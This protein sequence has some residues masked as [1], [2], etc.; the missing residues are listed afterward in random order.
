M[1][2]TNLALVNLF[3]ADGN[4]RDALARLESATRDVRVQEKRVKALVEKQALGHKQLLDTQAQAKA[5]DLEVKSLDQHIEKLRNQQQVSRNNK[6]YQAFLVEINTAKLDKGKKEEEWLRLQES[7]E[8]KEKEQQDLASLIKQEQQKLTEMEQGI[9]ARTADLRA[10]IAK[11]KP[12]RDEAAKAVPA[13]FLEMFE[14]LADRLDGEAMAAVG[15]PDPRREEYVCMTCN[16]DLVIDVYNRLH[17]RDEPVPCPSCRRLLYIPD[18]LPLAAAISKKKPAAARK[19]GTKTKKAGKP[20]TAMSNGAAEDPHASLVRLL[21]NA[22][23]E[24]VKN[25]VAA[26]NDP[27]EC[28][29]RVDGATVGIFKGQNAG[30]LERTIR[31][32]FSEAGLNK[33]VQ[34]SPLA[35]TGPAA[36]QPSLDPV[37]PTP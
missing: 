11:L 21:S 23:G 3:K 6:E 29:V 5:L 1:G 28:E 13:K 10:E 37:G 7:V 24:S 31:F 22:Q 35:G 16:M 12:I 36:D 32:I 18:D 19:S 14:K 9:E 33:D 27:V 34:V 15:R 4:Y 20:V 2:P 25:A 17:S 26:G 8:Q 30:N